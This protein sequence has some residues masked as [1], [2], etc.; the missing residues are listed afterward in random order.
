M[1]PARVNTEIP[2][3]SL[4]AN[5][6]IKVGK[7]LTFHYGIS[8]VSESFNNSELEGKDYT[9]LPCYCGSQTC[10]GYLPFDKSIFD[11]NKTFS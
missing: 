4:F 3:L 7:V 9:L 6:K 10:L 1:V 2:L 8:S 5:R 11:V